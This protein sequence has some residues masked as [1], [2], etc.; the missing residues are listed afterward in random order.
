MKK[1]S[2]WVM[3]VRDS[4]TQGQFGSLAAAMM[5]AYQIADG[6]DWKAAGDAAIAGCSR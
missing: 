4:C 1:D 5:C 3:K 6:F 2:V